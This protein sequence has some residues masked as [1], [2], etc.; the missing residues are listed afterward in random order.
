MDE[1][2]NTDL[3]PPPEYGV[4]DLSYRS[5]SERLA[6][7][8]ETFEEQ[9]GNDVNHHAPAHRNT[10]EEKVDNYLNP[11]ASV[12]N[13][14][15]TEKISP[16]II[17]ESV[18]S[19]VLQT[20]KTYGPLKETDSRFS[21]EFG[22]EA[23]AFILERRGMINLLRSDERFGSYDDIICLKGDAEKAKKMKD[24]ENIA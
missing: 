8:K 2:N 10:L 13:P 22:P 18:K 14:N 1:F 16:A 5:R 6:A 11:N 19:F 12:F 4:P 23:K 21:R 20:L 9:S 7:V 24:L 15:P 17:E 3:P